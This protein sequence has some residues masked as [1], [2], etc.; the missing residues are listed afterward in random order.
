MI[1]QSQCFWKETIQIDSDKGYDYRLLNVSEPNYPKDSNSITKFWRQILSFSLASSSYIRSLW[2]KVLKPNV[3]DWL[4]WQKYKSTFHTKYVLYTK[5][6]FHVPSSSPT[7]C[8]KHHSI[9]VIWSD[10]HTT[11]TLSIFQLH[12]STNLFASI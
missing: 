3:N 10:L 6:V 4:M 9:V 11:N 5:E 1:Y 7:I 2:L 12:P 8:C